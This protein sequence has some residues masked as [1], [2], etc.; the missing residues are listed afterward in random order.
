MRLSPPD[1]GDIILHDIGEGEEIYINYANYVA[2]GKCIERSWGLASSKY[3]GVLPWG[4]LMGLLKKKENEHCT[5]ENKS[6]ASGGTCT[7]AMMGSGT[8]DKIKVK[9]GMTI[10]VRR[11]RAIAYD[12][13]I[14]RGE[15]EAM[16]GGGGYKWWDTVSGAVTSGLQ[17]TSGA[18]STGWNKVKARAFG[19]IVATFTNPVDSGKDRFVWVQSRA[20]LTSHILASIQDAVSTSVGDNGGK[21]S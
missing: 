8:V 12:S 10:R 1:M 15:G 6:G 17:K 13:Q 7:V 5:D 16:F 9:P 19:H 11:G 21:S 3:G 20:P 4:E 14:K 2:S 18:L